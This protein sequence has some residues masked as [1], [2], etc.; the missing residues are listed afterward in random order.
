[1]RINILLAGRI[2][3]GNANFIDKK[4]F[5][6]PKTK[7]WFNFAILPSCLRCL[8]RWRG[9]RLQKEHWAPSGLTAKAPAL[10]FLQSQANVSPKM[11]Q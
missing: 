3:V 5:T 8:R 1:M 11:P 9:L 2:S 7:F 4:T 10:A 6:K